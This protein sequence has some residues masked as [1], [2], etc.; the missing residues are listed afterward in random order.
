MAATAALTTAYSV[1]KLPS[2]PAG[3][4]STHVTNPPTPP[5]RARQP[6]YLQLVAQFCSYSIRQPEARLLFALAAGSATSWAT[7]LKVGRQGSSSGPT[8]G[9]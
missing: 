1:T 7:F 5:L 2:T 6:L 8:M 4:P 3:R 9:A